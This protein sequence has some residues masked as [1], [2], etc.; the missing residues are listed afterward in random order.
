M[1][2][3]FL[4]H[5]WKYHLFDKTELI[6]STGEKIEIINVGQKNIDAGPDFF[7]AK[8]KINNTVWAG[9]VEV[10]INSSDWLKHSHNT[11]KAYDN[12]ILHV[13]YNNDMQI[14]RTNGEAIPT[15]E[16]KFDKRIFDKYQDLIKNEQWV[17]CEDEIN[18]VDGFIIDFWL[19]SLLIERLESKSEYILNNL[20]KNNNNW[21][22]TFYQQ[23][24]KNFGTKINQFPFEQLTKSLPLIYLAKHKN[25]L[26]QIEALLFGQAG[27][28]EINI[29]DDYYNS[30]KKEYLFLK[31]K[32]KLKSIE[33]HLWKF[34]RLRPGN[35]PTIRIA[36]FAALI[37]K[38]SS[39]FSKIIE[40][41]DLIEIKKH[42][43]VSASEYWD[44]HYIFGKTTKK[45][46]KRTGQIFIN[47]LI[48]NTIVPFLFVYSKSKDNEKYKIR[49]LKFLEQLPAEK[50]SIIS[51]WKLLKM[52]VPNAFYSQALIQLKNEYCNKKKCLYCQI[53]NRI[54]V[55][56]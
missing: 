56:K 21:E 31:D 4:Q 14:T 28:L 24:A 37:Y 42:F 52:P 50:N 8:V 27:F 10:H 49:A 1:N 15:I 33:K 29:D 47:S 9:N 17:S 13:V 6:A 40:T 35:F 18:N 55:K 20:Y 43:S 36:Q 54:I 53:G 32:F 5:I 22:E 34:L 25:S 41:D 12:V 2:E 30:L 45:R 7:N 23:L 26:L 38:S 48:I 19:N 11:D 39:L 3:A 16:L 46:K 44:T 51:N